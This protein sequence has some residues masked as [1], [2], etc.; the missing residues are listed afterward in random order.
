[1][2]DPT[3]KVTV[4]LNTMQ[5]HQRR[6]E[7]DHSRWIS[8]ISPR[9]TGKSTGVML[10]VS[11]RC[12]RTPGAEWVV[13]G[14]TRPSVKRI[15]WAPLK[16]L[17]EQLELGL[18]FNDQELVARFPN[19]SKIY[20]VGGETVAEIEKL[21]GGRFH[22]AVID[23][24][25]SYGE[26]VFADLLHEILQPALNT[27]RGPLILIGT[28]GDILRG[29][30]Y[31]ATCQPAEVLKTAGGDRLSN[32]LYGTGQDAS[33]SLH[34]WTLADN[35]AVPHL[36]ED[37]LALKLRNGWADDHP[38]WMREYLGLWVTSDNRLV[39]RYIPHKHDYTPD[40][41]GRFGLAAGHT[42]LTMVGVD[43]G[44]RDGT[45]IVVWAFSPTHPGCWEVHSE[46]RRKPKGEKFP[47][48]ELVEWYREVEQSFGP[49]AA[50]VADPQGSTMTLD[51]LADDHQIY[52]EAAEKREK[53]DAIGL[54]NLDL[55]RGL[56]H[57]LPGSPLSEE[58][59]KNRWDERKLALGKR[60][61]DRNIPN[62]TC[63][64]GLYG[65][66][67]CRHRKAQTPVDSVVDQFI[68]RQLAELEAAKAAARQKANPDDYSGLDREWWNDR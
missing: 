13:I 64:A 31:L 45:A 61:E 63:D 52:L 7:L 33:W 27:H 50:Q 67:W 39:Y 11:V 37:A 15:Y 19:G 35:T 38:V 48:S 10:L 68:A 51:T 1:M 57:I 56:I 26:L 46:V 55:D 49:Y 30:F 12:L 66:R 36:W 43:L 44:V 54:F 18:K 29:E 53:N 47:L 28:P 62:D 59:L 65:W 42:W 6:L 32:H 24:C 34:V 23:E 60:E 20:F 40:G 3:D 5:A 22:G 41:L 2:D 17:N 9:Q 58:L 21:R 25:A 4:L 8:V 14:L 16:K